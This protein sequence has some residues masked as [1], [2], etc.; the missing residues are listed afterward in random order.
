MLLLGSLLPAAVLGA[1]YVHLR[2][3]PE[4]TGQAAQFDERLAE[5]DAAVVVLGSS[6]A[7]RGIDV[8]TL[9]REL[10]VSESDIVML[11]LPHSSSAHWYAVLKNR[12]FANGHRPRLVLIVG[13]MTTFLNH[14]LLALQPNVERLVAQL[15]DDEPVIAGKVFRFDDSSEF[16]TFFMRERASRYRQELLDG[17]RNLVVSKLFARR[18]SE[19]EGKRLA[20]KVNEEVFA[21]ANM[22]YSLHSRAPTGLAAESVATMESGEFDLRR[23]ALVS[24]LQSLADEYE[25]NLVYVRYPFPPSN[26]NMDEVPGAIETDALDW[27]DEVGSGFVDMRSLDLGDAMYE[28]MRH[29]TREGAAKFTSAVGRAVMGMEAM[30]DGEAVGV[31]RGLGPPSDVAYTGSWPAL[32]DLSVI[33]WRTECR[34]VVPAGPLSVFSGVVRQ[35]LGPVRPPLAFFQGDTELDPTAFDKGC[36]ASWRL[37]DNALVLAPASPEPTDLRA[38]WREVPEGTGAS[39]HDALWLAPGQALTFRYDDPWTMPEYLFQV[40]LRGATVG[41]EPGVGLE[42][43]V[44]ESTFTVMPQDGRFYGLAS[45]PAPSTAWSLTVRSPENGPWALLHHLAV[46]T[47]PTTTYLLGEAETLHGAS[48]RIIGGRAEDVRSKPVFAKDP[49]P[50]PVQ[51]RIKDGTRQMGLFSMAR[52]AGLADAPDTD[53]ARPNRCTPVRVLEDGEPLPQPHAVCYD[54]MTK[55]AGRSCFAGEEFHFSASD[56]TDPIDNG[57]RY[58]IDLDPARVCETWSQKKATTLRDSYWL[59]PGDVLRVTAPERRTQSFHVGP[60]V[61]E[62]EVLPH[63]A[64]TDEPLEVLLRVNGEVVLEETWSPIGTGRRRDHSFPIEPRLAPQPG[65]VEVEIRNPSSRTF[66]LLTMVT[67]AEREELEDGELTVQTNRRA[68]PVL[69]V[70]RG[71]TVP[72][73]PPIKKIT[74]TPQG[75]FEARIFPLWPV[76]DTAL[77]KLRLPPVSPLRLK[78]DGREL[79]RNTLREPLRGGCEDCFSHMGQAVVYIAPNAADAV[80]EAWLDPAL[81]MVDAEGRESWWVYPGTWLD[82]RLE[83]IPEGDVTITVDGHAFHPQR[84]RAGDQAKISVGEYQQSFTR[85]GKGTD[86]SVR[87]MLY[88]ADA[89]RDAWQLRVWSDSPV[90]YLLLEELRIED[91]SGRSWVLP[92][93]G[94][95]D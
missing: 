62:M 8:S 3:P 53:H 40:L 32:P 81:P 37:E 11:Q 59:Y 19:E 23:D 85:V 35:R 63:L 77:E 46:G 12:V 42:V 84:D 26:R 14:D 58:K 72:S 56:S 31:I 6:L 48:V 2:Q 67:L 13:A 86:S 38:A 21:N 18:G 50:F 45:L 60:N 82:F 1:G 61:L 24:D 43:E 51:P 20:E 65:A 68:A 54:V 70:E 64:E 76:S 34:G 89:P 79:T 69:G 28:D 55:G 10:R 5:S 33:D 94:E 15:T 29:M 93:V 7:N 71:G 90:A 16:R 88:L 95:E 78:A 41:G 4:L 92:R 30:D 22:D 27:M 74:D 83:G 39:V 49:P 73:V 52:Y 87:S 91:A 47:P 57:R 44:D 25:A 75:G 9:A 66:Q 17:W 80:L 36:A